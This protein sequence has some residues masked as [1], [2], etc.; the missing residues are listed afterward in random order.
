[1][2]ANEHKNSEFQAVKDELNDNQDFSDSVSH[3]VTPDTLDY[4]KL[5]ALV[6]AGVMLVVVLVFIAIT[7]FNYFTFQS[8]QNAAVNAVFYELEELRA[9]HEL[10]LTT[11]GVVDEQA[12]IFRVPVDS[13]ITLI[14][15]EYTT[16]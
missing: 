7:M 2:Q 6:F 11:F 12:G 10:E 14:V 16:P 5:F 15:N 1:M 8:S 3:G 13:A 9:K 4:G